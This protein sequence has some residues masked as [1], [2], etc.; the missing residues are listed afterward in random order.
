MPQNVPAFRFS[1]DAKRV[2]QFIYE[3]WC[4]HGRGPNLREAHGE[5]GLSRERLV[6]VYRELDLGLIVTIQQDTQNVN[7]LKCQPF[8][9]YPS[10]VAVHVGGRFHCWAGC[11]MESIAFSRMPPFA[12]MTMT[13]ESY[14][15]CC[16]APITIR[17]RD[18]AVLDAAPADPLIHVSTSPREWNATDIVCMCDSMN[19]VVDAAHAT[20]YEKQV[21]RRGVLFTLAQAERFVAGTGANRMHRYDWD[22]VPLVPARVLAGIKALGVDVSNWE[23]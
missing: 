13:L 1:D 12:G 15:A 23:A 21:A 9:S 7:L 3:H 17:V 11:A 10:Q 6:E 8:S 22:P 5:T 18:G 19:F 16:L 4:R 14:C 20:A 2:R